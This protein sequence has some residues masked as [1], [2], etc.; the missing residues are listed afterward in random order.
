MRFIIFH[1]SYANA[2]QPSQNALN[3]WTTY[4]LPLDLSVSYGVRYV[5]EVKI[6]RGQGAALTRNGE[7][8]VPDYVVHDA[9]VSWQATRDLDVRMNVNNLFDKYYWSPTTAAA[10]ATGC[11]ARY[12]G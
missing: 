7:T 6:C 2:K 1:V 3:L 11:R 12:A 9:M 8:T 10:A 5:D 4:K